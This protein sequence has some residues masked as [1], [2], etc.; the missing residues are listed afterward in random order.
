MSFSAAGPQPPH[1]P[2]SGQPTPPTGPPERPTLTGAM[3]IATELW[4]VV[5]A[6][7]IVTSIGM[8]Q[9]VRDSYTSGASKSEEI[10]NPMFLTAYV[11]GNLVIATISILVWWYAREGRKVARML[12]SF[13]AVYVV[14]QTVMAFF[15]Q[16]DP[17]W[18]MIP[19]VLAGVAGLGVAAMV[20]SRDTERFC[21]EMDQYRADVARWRFFTS[22]PYPLQ[23]HPHQHP[24]P[25]PP[26]SYPPVSNPHGQQPPVPPADERKDSNE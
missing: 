25:Y 5:I 2:G 13:G 21:A 3:A 19:T 11:I 24:G 22:T 4:L 1:Q 26:V 12:L 20:L 18:V 23:V 6:M 14:V 7:E 8:Y 15:S 16:P 10:S 9:S 17:R